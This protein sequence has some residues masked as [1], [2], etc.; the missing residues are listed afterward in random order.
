MN[1]SLDEGML[2]YDLYAALLSFVNRK[3]DVIPEPFSNA[4]EYMS[5]SP[6][7]KRTIRGNAL[8]LKNPVDRRVRLRKSGTIVNLKQLR[9]VGTWKEALPGKFYVFLL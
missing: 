2:F 5:V 7:V 6:E 8:T 3:L 4:A 1:L 9:I